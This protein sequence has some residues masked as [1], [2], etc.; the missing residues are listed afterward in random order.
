MSY[1]A[2][3]LFFNH[4]RYWKLSIRCASSFS[5]HSNCADAF[6]FA[7]VALWCDESWFHLASLSKA[8]AMLDYKLLRLFSF[9]NR[10]NYWNLS[11]SCARSFSAFDSRKCFLLRYFRF[12]Y[13][14]RKRLSCVIS[15]SVQKLL[16]PKNKHTF[17][18]VT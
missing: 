8:F 2:F 1:S 10:R 4:L 7:F 11:I 12:L 18:R 6:S 13:M 16:K 17:K 9:F 3:F 15:P 5:A 14:R